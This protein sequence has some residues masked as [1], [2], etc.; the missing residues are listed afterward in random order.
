MGGEVKGKLADGVGSQ[1]P[2]HYLR[3]WRIQHQY[4]R[5]VFTSAVSSQLN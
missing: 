1:Y 2:S 3:T 5:C 4:R